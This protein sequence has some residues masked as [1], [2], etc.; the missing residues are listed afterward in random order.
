MNKL[1]KD[2]I[3][4]IPRV[5]NHRSWIKTE[6]ARLEKFRD[7]HKGG[8]C[9]LIGNGPS[10][11]KMNLSL[12]NDYYTIGLN[13]IFL[14]F[15]KSGMRIDYH[16][17][18]NKY[19]IEQCLSEFEL[20]ECPSFISYKHG[21]KLLN[22]KEKFY[23]LGD[24][25]SKWGFFEDI[26]KGICQGNTVT[27]SALQ[28]AYFMG[29][30]R[31]FLIGVDHN[32]VQKGTPHKVETMKGDDTSHFDPDYF[33]GLKWQLPDLEGSEMA[34]KLAREHFEKDNRS[35]FDATV[36]GKLEVF[37]KI[38]FEDALKTAIKK[39]K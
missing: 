19:V 18:V 12:L 3:S 34:Y 2:T 33:R 4:F 36:G 13:K 25:H 5:I 21:R 17:C 8:D 10:L 22:K 20:M 32:F 39:K 37:T 7:I 26:T 6:S 1:L 28:I 31:V 23:F 30:K 9:I 14:L 38:S 16:V 27:Y 15:D 24:I 11:N 29:F 35:V